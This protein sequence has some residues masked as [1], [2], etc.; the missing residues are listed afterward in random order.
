[1]GT[2]A[3][4][5]GIRGIPVIQKLQIAFAW[6][7]LVLG[8]NPASGKLGWGWIPHLKQTHLKPLLEQGAVDGLVW[9]TARVACG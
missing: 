2:S 8:V 3:P 9:D 7:Y 5:R 4:R 1:M 6:R